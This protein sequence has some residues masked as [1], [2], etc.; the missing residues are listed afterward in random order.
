MM[1]LTAYWLLELAAD[2]AEDAPAVTRDCRAPARTPLC[3]NPAAPAPWTPQPQFEE[4]ASQ[5]AWPH[6]PYLDS[7]GHLAV[8]VHQFLVEL[9]LDLL[10][11]SPDISQED[12]VDSDTVSQEAT[13]DTIIPDIMDT[14]CPT[15]VA[16]M[17]L[18]TMALEVLT[19]FTDQALATMA[20]QTGAGV[21]KELVLLDL[22][23][24][25]SVLVHGSPVSLL[26][27][28]QQGLPPVPTASKQ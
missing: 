18:A 3:P 2:L 13:A 15:G 19:A 25:A 16:T 14:R 21:S 10:V 22:D 1:A 28:L 7:Q 4:P 5:A 20:P 11:V 6:L 9:V 24:E 12:L 23:K 27:H 17:A 26:V 8:P